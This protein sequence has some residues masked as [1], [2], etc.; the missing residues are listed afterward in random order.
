MV[1]LHSRKHSVC[2]SISLFLCCMICP[3][4][5]AFN[6]RE[7]S[8]GKTSNTFSL[9]GDEI[10]CLGDDGESNCDKSGLFADQKN[11]CYKC[12]NSTATTGKLN[13]DKLSFRNSKISTFPCKNLFD[14]LFYPLQNE[15]QIHNFLLL[16]NCF[17][18]S[19]ETFLTFHGSSIKTFF[20]VS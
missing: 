3:L 11:Q 8:C 4:S 6:T 10:S 5:H 2:L 1:F 19:T 9:V 17:W 13:S 7:I 14:A 16:E 20:R 15:N 18:L 12:C